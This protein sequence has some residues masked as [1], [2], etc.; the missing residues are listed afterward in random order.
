MFCRLKDW[1]RI[2]TRFDRNEKLHR[3]NRPCRRRHLVAVMSPDPSLP[4]ASRDV[5]LD[6]DPTPDAVR[7]Q[8]VELEEI[9]KRLGYA[10]GI[11]HPHDATIE[12]LSEWL[13]HAEERGFILVPISAI[14]Q[15]RLAKS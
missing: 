5:F 14:V 10:V 8:I 4:F 11:G 2:A 13:Q 12:V 7:R 3:R 15:R 6:N 9:A 1:R